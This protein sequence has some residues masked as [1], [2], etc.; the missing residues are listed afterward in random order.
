MTYYFYRQHMETGRREPVS[1]ADTFR[2]VLRNWPENAGRIVSFCK[3]QGL[4]PYVDGW[5]YGCVLA[6]DKGV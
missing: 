2:A 1:E 6:M 4:Q 3:R 5:I